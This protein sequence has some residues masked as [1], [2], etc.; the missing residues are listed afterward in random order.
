VPADKL[1]RAARGEPVDFTGRGVSS[2]GDERRVE[3]RATPTG[4]SGGRIR[5][6]IYVT[7]RISLTFDTT[8]ELRGAAEPHSQAKSMTFST[9][10][11]R[12]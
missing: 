9:E 2:S 7:R 8:Y 3:G 4:P 1:L 11:A 10:G 6:R 12:L 5:V